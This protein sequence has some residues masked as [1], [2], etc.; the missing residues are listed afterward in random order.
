MLD[1]LRTHEELRSEADGGTRDELGM[2]DYERLHELSDVE[3]ELDVGV[4][5]KVRDGIALTAAEVGALRAAFAK[6]QWR[7]RPRGTSIRPPRNEFALER[8]GTSST[9]ER[10]DIGYRYYTWVSA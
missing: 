9:T 10:T 3:L 4:A 8:L 2:A 7:I 6:P 5:S 1:G